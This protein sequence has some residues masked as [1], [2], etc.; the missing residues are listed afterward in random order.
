MPRALLVHPSAYSDIAENIELW[1]NEISVDNR[2]DYILDLAR[3]QQQAEMRIKA[4]EYDFIVSH[5]NIQYNK[6]TSIQDQ[7]L[8][9]NGLDLLKYFRRTN[10]NVPVLIIS[11]MADSISYTDLKPFEPA[12][13]IIDGIDLEQDF[14]NAVRR[15]FTHSSMLQDEAEDKIAYI[16]I[17]IL[18]GPG[19]SYYRIQGKGFPFDARGGLFFNSLMINSLGTMSDEIAEKIRTRDTEW[20]TPLV[21]L[22]NM[23]RNHLFIKKNEDFMN[24]YSNVLGLINNRVENLRFRFVV[25]KV[26]HKIIFEALM[27]IDS[28][29]IMMHAPMHRKLEIISHRYALFQDPDDKK[30]TLNCLVIRA[31]VSGIVN[32]L[33]IVLDPIPNVD[34]EVNFW[35]RNL[36][37]NANLNVTIIDRPERDM[38]YF[39]TIMQYLRTRHWDIVHFAGHSAYIQ[40]EDNNREGYLFFP[41][42]NIGQIYPVKLELFA[43]L[44]YDANVKLVYLSSCHSSERGFVFEMVKRNVPA[45]VGFRWDIEDRVAEIFMK[46]FYTYLMDKKSLE[47]SFLETRKD[48][49]F[50]E[51]DNPIWAA[52]MLVIQI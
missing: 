30:R 16:D 14:K 27:G 33:E 17:G 24:S 38:T 31:D 20:R 39:D 25:D 43:S 10:Y 8:R 50:T 26:T 49:Y 6:D 32:E 45:V 15:F 2:G 47:V 34:H 19:R 35:D 11:P 42:K 12:D 3:Y 36:R 46:K 22:G 37:E 28:D 23:I 40:K 4:E 29:F 44:L 1:L 9:R 18:L 7:Q 5:L 51:Q 41:G 21:E 13:L 52:A 48:L